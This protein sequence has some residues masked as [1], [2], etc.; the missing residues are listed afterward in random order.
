MDLSQVFFY[1]L[2]ELVLAIV[3]AAAADYSGVLSMMLQ[4]RI[5]HACE[6]EMLSLK[7]PPDTAISVQMAQYGFFKSHSMEMCPFHWG[8]PKP[9]ASTRCQ[10]SNAYQVV[11]DE[12]QDKKHCKILVQNNV[13]VINSCPYPGKYL[14]V[15]YKCRPNEFRNIVACEDNKLYL[16]CS[17]SR[18]LVIYSA[19]FG[20]YRHGNL[21]CPSS[22]ETEKDCLSN[23]ALQ[24]V[25]KRCH[26]KRSCGVYARSGVFGDPCRPN[27]EKYLDVAYTCVPKK[28]LRKPRRYQSMSAVSG[29]PSYV[30]RP[31]TQ[32]YDETTTA[33]AL[34][35]PEH[36]LSDDDPNLWDGIYD[37]TDI[38]GSYIY[39]NKSTVEIDYDGE[40][41][42]EP[43]GLIS[44]IM[45]AIGYIRL[46]KEKALLY[47]TISICC[48]IVLFLAAVVINL[49][50]KSGCQAK[51][52]QKDHD[53]TV[54]S[55]EDHQKRISPSL[56]NHVQ[57]KDNEERY[58][59]IRNRNSMEI[60][61]YNSHVDMSIGSGNTLPPSRHMNT[62][63]DGSGLSG[64]NTLPRTG[65]ADTNFEIGNTL[66][67]P[68]NNYSSSTLPTLSE[69]NNYYTHAN[70]GKGR[71]RGGNRY[72]SHREEDLLMR[73]PRHIFGRSD[74]NDQ[75]FDWYDYRSEMN[76]GR[77]EM[78]SGR[79]DRNNVEYQLNPGTSVRNTNGGLGMNVA[80]TERNYRGLGMNT[81]PTE[82]SNGA[83]GMSSTLTD[84]NRELG[85]SSFPTERNNVGLGISG[86]PTERNNRGLGMRSV[87]T[88]RSHGALGMNRYPIERSAGGLGLNGFPTERNTG[89]FQMNS[90][91][92]ERSNA[93]YDMNVGVT[94]TNNN[95][96]EMNVG[97]IDRTDE[98]GNVHSDRMQSIDELIA[99]LTDCGGSWSGGE[100]RE[101]QQS[102]S[103]NSSKPRPFYVPSTYPPLQFSTEI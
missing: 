1:G 56:T 82:R 10:A 48:G 5:G 74:R 64:G 88:E 95:E 96:F 3:H 20:R 41:E 50:C 91:P 92:S 29:L 46:N 28:I 55:E 25:M 24:Q 7:C 78:N 33:A 44:D 4:T 8:T 101:S 59:S 42:N 73:E 16:E 98:L 80:P 84:K 51:K 89:R 21:N 36:S 38:N 37:V 18:V 90:L 77:P 71:T 67:N 43:L 76:S 97:G 32:S 65:Y 2:I 39:N 34:F 69:I 103:T 14:E 53:S 6:N 54:T 9:D 30:P 57:N 23:V 27:V 81:L 68:R 86:V 15:T 93:R 87:P 45:S 70:L 49:I 83:L 99:E 63:L 94:E 22:V 35:T 11:F 52:Q 19:M 40:E 100:Q 17:L 60:L 75:R 31:Q 85:L 12:C 26:G 72:G 58:A 61:Q 47:M 79:Q 62:S 102:K 13:F 66:P